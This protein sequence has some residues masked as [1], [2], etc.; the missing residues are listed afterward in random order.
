MKGV[1][2][3]VVSQGVVP[4][5]MGMERDCRRMGMYIWT[6]LC[7]ESQHFHMYVSRTLSS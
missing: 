4:V 1:W 2:E 6:A 5:P 3:E 7:T